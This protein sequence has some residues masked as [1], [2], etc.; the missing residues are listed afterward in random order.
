M[1]LILAAAAWIADGANWVG[2]RGIAWRL[3]QHLGVSALV[4]VISA[5]IALPLG[6]YI[7]HSGR[8]KWLISLTGAV[9]A[10]PT[11][12]TDPVW[13][14]DRY[15]PTGASIGASCFSDPTFASWSLQ[16][17]GRGTT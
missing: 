6:I 15:W 9:R 4:L 17:R 16:W 10:V 2:Q 14:L 13:A 5:A 11:R 8:G 7:G 12:F 1:S 3:V